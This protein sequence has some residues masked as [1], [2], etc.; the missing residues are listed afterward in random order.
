ML[1]VVSIFL[2]DHDGMELELLN[3]TAL[4]FYSFAS[5]IFDDDTIVWR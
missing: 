3:R 4:S 2:T 1:M 5:N